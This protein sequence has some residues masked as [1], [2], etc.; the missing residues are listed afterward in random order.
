MTKEEKRAR[1]KTKKDMKNLVHKGRLYVA[2]I[3]LALLGLVGTSY[4]SL[5]QKLIV[6]GKSIENPMNQDASESRSGHDLDNEKNWNGS[7][8]WNHATQTLRLTNLKSNIEEGAIYVEN[9][10][11]LTIEV[12]GECHFLSSKKNTSVIRGDESNMTIRGIGQ[13]AELI[14]RT[15]KVASLGILI[16]K[17]RDLYIDNCLV[18]VK[19]GASYG[20]AGNYDDN[21]TGIII[22][23]G[24]A[25]EAWGK[26]GSIADIGQYFC[27][28]EGADHREVN[29]NES[30]THALTAIA[31]DRDVKYE[32]G[33]I[34]YASGADAGTLVKE[35]WVVITPYYP[36]M[37]G[38]E[39]LRRYKSILKSEDYSII[40]SG[41]V[42]YN[43]KEHTLTLKDATI[44]SEGGNVGILSN[45]PS[46][47]LRVVCIGANKITTKAED[48]IKTM[49]SES[50]V[51]EGQGDNPSLALYPATGQDYSG[52]WDRSP[53]TDDQLVIRDIDL[54]IQSDGPCIFTSVEDKEISLDFLNATLT[55]IQ[56]GYL[57]IEGFE[58][59]G[60][61]NA[62]IAS[63]LGA[64]V[65][66]GT[67]K[68]NGKPLADATCEIK[69]GDAPSYQITIDPN[70]KNGKITLSHNGSVAYGTTVT[71]TV[72][73]DGGYKL[74]KLT[75]N[76]VDITATKTFIVQAAT[77]VSATFTRDTAIEEVAT[78]E[79]ILY[80]N[81]AEDAATLSGV[82]PGAMV[83][84]FSLDGV[85]VLR[86]VANEAGVARLDLAGVAAGKYLVKSG[87]TTVVLLVTK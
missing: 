48:C 12:V 39:R 77:M 47:Y 78:T 46:S 72:K 80:P 43:A 81:P 4:T 20:V 25:L 66:G 52:I 13:G 82:E 22:S 57:L 18:D 34:V 75:A 59:I 5:A 58:T 29:V 68:L 40:E 56:S 32:N 16:D 2:S 74:A 3:A 24:G 53:K 84:V 60:L 65:E 62:Y 19:S 63:P 26:S 69:K 71:V 83:Q 55:N 23:N 54:K 7:W 14:I 1:H 17:N 50:P 15:D 51:I 9:I 76:G 79:A 87:E 6:L 37:V 11:N 21:N 61:E 36:I 33:D 42:E 44:A 86:T 27:V 8:S 73:P 85:E 38:G 10:F 31:P 30:T 35:H 67:I 28:E 64:V 45:H 70:M 49:D 41:E